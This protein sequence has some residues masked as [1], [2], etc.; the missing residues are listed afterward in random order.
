MNREGR[1]VDELGLHPGFFTLRPVE[2][3]LS[4][5]VHEMVHHWQ[6]SF[7]QPSRSNPH[8]KQW[9]QKMRAV[10]LEPSST[11]LPQGSDT[12][13]GVSHYIV[14]DGPFIQACRDLMAQGFELIWFDRHLPRAQETAE[15]HQEAL[16][17][18]GVAVEVSAPPVAVMA[19]AF[20]DKPVL[21]APPMRR[22]VDRVK[23]VCGG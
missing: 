3:V 12:G 8:N 21:V 11:G 2:E 22:E 23:Y 7:G 15:A 16:R 1:T 19:A 14:P 17:A 13:Q 20:P 5:L 6:D 10:G 4:T 9:A 18:A